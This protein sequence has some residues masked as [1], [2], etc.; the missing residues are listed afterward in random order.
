MPA[1]WT[2]SAIQL[3]VP[4][5]VVDASRFPAV[6][7]P[8]VG[9]DLGTD[10]PVLTPAS[11]G[12]DPDVATDGSNFLVVFE[13]FQRIRAVRADGNGNLLSF[14]WIDLGGEAPVRAQR[15]LRRRPY[16]VTW[17]E[18]DGVILTVKG[19][20]STPTGR[21]S[22]MPTSPSRRRTPSTTRWPGTATASW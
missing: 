7:D 4:A 13:D 17:W 16:L 8:V 21:R 6:L 12:L 19:A 18:D 10:R 20:R 14:D 5:G 22:A 2:G 1:R 9:P 15:R 3:R 11:G